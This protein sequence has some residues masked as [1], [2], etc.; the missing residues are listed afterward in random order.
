MGAALIAF[1]QIAT[2]GGQILNGKDA[3]PMC[4]KAGILGTLDLV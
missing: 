2:R 1:S 4:A 3:N